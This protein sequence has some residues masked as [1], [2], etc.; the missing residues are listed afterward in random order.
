MHPVCCTVCIPV[1]EK[2]LAVATSYICFTVHFV[3]CLV[4]HAYLYKLF[5]S[6]N[7]SYCILL[8]VYITMHAWH[9]TPHSTVS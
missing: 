9:F 4:V 1:V 6:F 7:D 8:F 2:N 3:K 5:Y